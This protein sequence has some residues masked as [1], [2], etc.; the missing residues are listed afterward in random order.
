MDEKKIKMHLPKIAD[1]FTTQEERDNVNNEKVIELDINNIGFKLI[2]FIILLIPAAF[3]GIGFD[4]NTTR[5]SGINEIC[6]CVPFAILERA[7][8]GSPC[9][10]VHKIQISF[11]FKL[12]A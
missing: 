11:F 6:L 4:E 12:F 8:S 7:A 5:S 2:N 9:E 1:L 3:P 10:P